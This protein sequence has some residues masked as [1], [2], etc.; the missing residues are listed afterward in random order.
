MINRSVLIVRPKQACLD[1]AA[2]LESAGPLPDPYAEQ[3]VYM[4]P[5]FE[6]RE[7][8]EEILSSF[9]ETVFERQLLSWHADRSVWPQNR[10]INAFREWFNVELHSVVED[11]CDYDLTDDKY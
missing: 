6:C 5:C 4:I 2:G 1:W 7:D 3:T 8:A 11:L 9:Y 10:D